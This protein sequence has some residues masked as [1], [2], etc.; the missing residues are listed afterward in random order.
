M[1]LYTCCTKQVG[2]HQCT[3]P[4]WGSGDGMGGEGG[5]AGV[6]DLWFE[7]KGL[8]KAGAERKS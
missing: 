3:E 8:Q 7:L 5:G 2:T 6:I 1:I 4:A